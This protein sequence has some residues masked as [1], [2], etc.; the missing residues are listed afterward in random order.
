MFSTLAREKAF[1]KRGRILFPKGG[2]DMISDVDIDLWLSGV[3][4]ENIAELYIAY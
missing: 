3:L 2:G 1:Q 4:A